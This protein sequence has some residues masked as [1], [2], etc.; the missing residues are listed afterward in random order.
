MVR[1]KQTG[2][3]GALRSP[4]STMGSKVELSENFLESLRAS[5]KSKKAK[6]LRASLKYAAAG[7]DQ[8]LAG[9]DMVDVM[10]E[11]TKALQ[12][13]E[14]DL[15]LRTLYGLWTKALLEEAEYKRTGVRMLVD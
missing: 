8:A 6:E 2:W 10:P 7:I 12:I 15:H 13:I 11:L 3:N 1:Q 5:A 14:T 9:S 4:S